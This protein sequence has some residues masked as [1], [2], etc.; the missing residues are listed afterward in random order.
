VRYDV[1]HPGEGPRVADLARAAVRGAP[2]RSPGVTGAGRP[3]PDLRPQPEADLADGD[4]WIEDGQ[5]NHAFEVDGSL[6]SLRGT[7][8]LK[9]L[10]GQALYEISKPLAPHLHK[11][12]DI[13]KGGQTAATV[14]EAIFHL[15]ATSSRSRSPAAR[16]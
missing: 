11:T 7:H 9:D 15:G 14:Q 1:L 10:G 3:D 4:L 5:R 6:L 13:T 12:I 16:S 8:V 2:E